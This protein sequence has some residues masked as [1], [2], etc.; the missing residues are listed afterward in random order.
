MYICICVKLYLICISV[1]AALRSIAWQY[2]IERC[3]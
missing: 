2:H 1:D 3:F